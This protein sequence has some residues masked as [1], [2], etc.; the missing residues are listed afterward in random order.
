MSSYQHP[1]LKCRFIQTVA[2]QLAD[3]ETPP[4][5]S[6]A[7]HALTE[8]RPALPLDH[9]NCSQ[10]LRSDGRRFILAGAPSRC[11]S[12]RPWLV[13]VLFGWASLPFARW[14]SSMR[15]SLHRPLRRLDLGFPGDVLGG[16]VQGEVQPSLGSLQKDRL[17][18][19]GNRLS[20]GSPYRKM[21]V[22]PRGSS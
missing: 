20:H 22:R 7:P 21:K 4:A 15:G 3:E 19:F 17:L 6:D 10:N 18:V 12:K 5:T 2:C 9:A 1:A 8:R 13:K 11:G 14:P 16:Q